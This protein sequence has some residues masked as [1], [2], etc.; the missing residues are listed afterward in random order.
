[1]NNNIKN[2]RYVVEITSFR[3][4][5]ARN[6]EK[7]FKVEF[8]TIFDENRNSIKEEIVDFIKITDYFKLAELKQSFLYLDFKSVDNIIGCQG[9]INVNNGY[10]NYSYNLREIAEEENIN[11]VF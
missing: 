10:V 11:I 8:K 6:G 5:T 7:L 9:L 1:M 2:G 4:I 3:K